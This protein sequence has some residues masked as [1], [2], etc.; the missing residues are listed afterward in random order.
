[1]GSRKPQPGG[2]SCAERQERLSLSLRSPVTMLHR[3]S[4]EQTCGSLKSFSTYWRNRGAPSSAHNSC[5]PC[6]G[7][8]P[9]LHPPG[10][11]SGGAAS[12]ADAPPAA[13]RQITGRRAR[14]SKT[15]PSLTWNQDSNCTQDPPVLTATQV[16]LRGVS[17]Q[18]VGQ[19]WLTSEGEVRESR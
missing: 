5:C 8:Q 11:L 13:L 15:F 19:D 10:F 14:I 1:M 18:Q 7:S 2:C 17:K 12:T 4:G 9:A 16:R 6:T 3:K